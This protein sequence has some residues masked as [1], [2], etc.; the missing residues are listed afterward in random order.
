[1]MVAR[2]I[3]DLAPDAVLYDVPLIPPRITNIP[4]FISTAQ[5]IYQ[6]I[7]LLITLLRLRPRWSGPWILVNAWSIYDRSTDHPPFGSYTENRQF[8]GHPMIN[9]VTQAVQQAISM[10]CSLPAIAVSSARASA[11]AASIA[12]PATA[13]GAPTPTRW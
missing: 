13:S 12:G 8:G 5:V 4:A 3:L 9:I 11:A 6:I 7:T 10:W 1:M 2:S